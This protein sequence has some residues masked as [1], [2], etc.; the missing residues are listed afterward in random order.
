MN[1]TQI[2]HLKPDKKCNDGVQDYLNNLL[3]SLNKINNEREPNNRT[4]LTEIMLSELIHFKFKKNTKTFIHCQ[5]PMIAW[6][7]NIFLP[8][9]ILFKLTNK[10]IQLIVTLHEWSNTHPIRRI[11]NYILIRASFLIIVPSEDLR[12]E[13]TKFN[14]IRKRNIEISVIPIGP[15]IIINDQAEIKQITENKETDN[16]LI[17]HFGFLYPLK[18][19]NKVLLTFNEI[20]KQISNSK[21]IFIGDFLNSRSKEKMQFK[22][23][24]SDLNLNNHL[25]F[26]GYLESETEVI[27]EMNKWSIYISLHENGFSLRHGSTL[28]A[29]QLGIPVISYEPKSLFSDFEQKWLEIIIKD[30]N[31]IFINKNL[32]IQQIAEVIVEKLKSNKKGNIDSLKWIWD[33]ISEMHLNLYQR[34]SNL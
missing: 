19:P 14:F 28:A 32:T 7:F 4:F 15:N 30:K 24:I 33:E 2:I 22:K 11:I 17:G 9:L 18:N 10:K 1:L 16:I 26:L 31:L 6:R 23:L 21:L 27:Q 13:I 20:N 3:H 8:L 5:L 29:L 25:Q 34:L 12:K